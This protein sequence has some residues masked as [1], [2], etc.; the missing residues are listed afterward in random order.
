MKEVVARAKQLIEQLPNNTYDYSRLTRYVEE[1]ERLGCTN[2]KCDDVYHKA[3]RET[4]QYGVLRVE[5]IFKNGG[6]FVTRLV[7]DEQ[8]NKD[9]SCERCNR[10]K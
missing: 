4:L 6:K 9:G 1:Y 3:V 2:S 8:H 10:R 7:F 5:T